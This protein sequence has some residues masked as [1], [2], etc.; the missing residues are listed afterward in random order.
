[1]RK[2]T[3][4]YAARGGRSILVRPW[5]C[6]C[7]LP[8]QVPPRALRPSSATSAMERLLFV[9]PRHSLNRA[10]RNQPGIGSAESTGR[11]FLPPDSAANALY[12][13]GASA[14]AE[15]F[16]VLSGD[17][18]RSHGA[19]PLLRFPLSS[20]G[21]LFAFLRQHRR[22]LAAAWCLCG[23]RFRPNCTDALPIAGIS[24]FSGCHLRHLRT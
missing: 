19:A 7:V 12:S 5:S 8:G 3:S 18:P 13:L 24:R 21:R 2:Q 22:E 9:R 10:S 17:K 4:S 14:G 6:L 1:M 16:V 20:R 15:A 11:P 23:Y